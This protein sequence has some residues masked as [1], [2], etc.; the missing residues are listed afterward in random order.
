MTARVQDLSGRPQP[1]QQQ[2]RVAQS[3]ARVMGEE[4]AGLSHQSSESQSAGEQIA[5]RLTR[6]T[7]RLT[8]AISRFALDADRLA[9]TKS[10]QDRRVVPFF[11]PQGRHVQVVDAASVLL[12]EQVTRGKVDH[13]V[14]RG[15][16][17]RRKVWFSTL[18]QVS[19]IEQGDQQAKG[20][21]ESDA[22]AVP[23][24]RKV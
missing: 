19:L 23:R 8:S 12:I 4:I 11:Q 6:E 21:A 16:S 17:R 20:L 7:G 15:H 22:C 5:A 9:A 2:S 24:R 10:G 1:A 13:H 18:L 3:V 14:G